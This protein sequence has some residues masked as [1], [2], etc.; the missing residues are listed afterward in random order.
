MNNNT[1]ILDKYIQNLEPIIALTRKM[2]T[3]SDDN[4][5][6]GLATTMA[7]RDQLLSEVDFETGGIDVAQLNELLDLN[8]SMQDPLELKR[9]DLAHQLK[10]MTSGR[11]GVAAY[12][13][14]S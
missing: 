14:V 12:N 5:F 6:A 9:N 11:K 10:G 2:V 1:E 13:S 4:E 8:N 7:E 3:L